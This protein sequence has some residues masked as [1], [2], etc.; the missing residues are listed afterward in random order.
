MGAQQTTQE[1]LSTFYTLPEDVLLEILAMVPLMD[2]IHRCRLVC[3]QWRDVIDSA[4][5]WKVKSQ[6]EGYITRVC[7]NFPK[8]W[9]IFYYLSKHKRN[10]LRNPC[11]LEKFNAWTIG[12]NGSDLWKIEDLPGELG[13]IFPDETVT[14]YFVTSYRICKKSQLIDL[15]KMGYSSEI[16]DSYQPDIVIKDWYGARQDC[17]CQYEL[18]VR[19]LSKRKA[20]IQEFAPERVFQGGQQ[21]GLKSV[22]WSDA[23]WRQM[24][25]R[26]SNYGPGVRYVYFQHGGK[27]TQFWAGWYGVRV[28]NSSVTIEPEDLSASYRTKKCLTRDML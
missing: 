27:D 5:L 28:T 24:S 21:R 23:S 10:L 4:T 9:K 6:R 17:G 13:D 19:L 22:Q 11:A 7:Q 25:Y 3:S 18:L 8:D 2:L 20:T 12:H 15:K 14:K 26:F 16:M 1:S